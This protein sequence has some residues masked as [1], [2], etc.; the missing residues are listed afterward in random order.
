MSKLVYSPRKITC[1]GATSPLRAPRVV[2]FERIRA[3]FSS[4][5]PYFLHLILLLPFS[6]TIIA[7]EEVEPAQPN[8]LSASANSWFVRRYS[9]A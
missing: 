8:R 9:Y 7:I 3:G 5:G 6:L 4:S 1:Y 2:R